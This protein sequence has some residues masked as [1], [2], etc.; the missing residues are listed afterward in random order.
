[1]QSML[2]TPIQAQTLDDGSRLD[3]WFHDNRPACD[4]DDLMGRTPGA[5]VD[6]DEDDPRLRRLEA[7]MIRI[8]S[9]VPGRTAFRP[10]DPCPDLLTAEEA[11]RYLRLDTMGIKNPGETL[12][13][14][15][16]EGHLKGT[17][18]S[19]RVFYLKSELD[20]FL[21]KMTDINPR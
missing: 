6:A 17:Q 14:Y 13:R 3:S 8:L 7:A 12:A 21:K 20:T 9:L 4:S 2:T 16:K 18:V 10:G 5:I 1:M 11:I 19:K 15:R